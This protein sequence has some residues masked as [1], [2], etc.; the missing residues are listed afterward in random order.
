MRYKVGSFWFLFSPWG[1]FKNMQSE[2]SWQTKSNFIIHT[3]QFAL[4]HFILK[5][6][7][8]LPTLHYIQFNYYRQ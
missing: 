8:L 3:L 7:Y 2:I 1:K 5:K 6:I 4:Q